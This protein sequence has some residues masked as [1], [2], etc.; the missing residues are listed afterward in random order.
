MADPTKARDLRHL[1]SVARKL[2]GLADDAMTANGDRE[3]FLTTAAALE[4][5]ANWMAA[6]LPGERYDAA[7]TVHLH[8]HVNLLV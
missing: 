6:A 4:A 1:L 7:A 3:L 8:T 2:R 5:R